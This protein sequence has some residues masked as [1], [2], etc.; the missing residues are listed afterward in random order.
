MLR[1]SAPTP[2]EPNFF[3][4]PKRMPLTPL[5]AL[6]A[7]FRQTPHYLGYS[8]TVRNRYH[9]QP[10][11]HKHKLQMAKKKPSTPAE[12]NLLL[13]TP[14]SSLPIVDTHT[15]VAATFEYYRGRYKA[16]RYIDVYEFVKAMYAD[17]NVEAV[18]DVWCEA[19]VRKLWKEFADSASDMEKWG[20]LQYW[21]VMG[22]RF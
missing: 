13:P 2:P 1:T 3:F 15:H 22:T 19:P 18:V 10:Q 21:F 11:N 14:P 4:S 5:L 16:G 8:I 9:S 6:K 7:H 12:E 17:R 20:G